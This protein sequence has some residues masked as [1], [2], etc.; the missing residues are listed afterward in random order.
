PP[1]SLPL[2]PS[3]TLFR[4]SMLSSVPIQRS[5]AAGGM[6]G[7]TRTFGQSVGAALVAISF[8][9]SAAYGAKL[10]L[11]LAVLCAL[12]AVTVNLIQ[13]RDPKARAVEEAARSG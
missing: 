1:A 9:I 10:A 13:L 8:G 6:Q 3:T 11:V 2:V 7:T 5:G 12:G 4:S